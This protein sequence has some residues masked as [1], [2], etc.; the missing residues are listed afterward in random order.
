[1]L[2]N[3][4]SHEL[5]VTR[6]RV[7]PGVRPASAVQGWR[8]VR[9]GWRIRIVHDK[10]IRGGR[11]VYVHNMTLWRRERVLVRVKT[12]QSPTPTS[13]TKR[14]LTAHSTSPRH[15]SKRRTVRTESKVGVAWADTVTANL[16]LVPKPRCSFQPTVGVEIPRR[17]LSWPSHPPAD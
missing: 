14:K 8:W 17:S 11:T 13:K 5:T 12:A 2:L 10:T 4:K 16:S 6:R 9:G 3:Q 15:H 7:W 1:M